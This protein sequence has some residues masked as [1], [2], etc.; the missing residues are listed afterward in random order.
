MCTVIHRSRGKKRGQG[1][2]LAGPGWE[3]KCKHADPTRLLSAPLRE[4]L[5]TAR[6]APFSEKDYSNCLRKSYMQSTDFWVKPQQLNRL[7]R[8][9]RETAN[10]ARPPG[11]SYGYR[12][13]KNTAR[14]MGKHCQCALKNTDVSSWK[15]QLGTEMWTH[16][17]ALLKDENI[18]IINPNLKEYL[19][20]IFL[21]L[22]AS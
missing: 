15:R 14:V 18:C 5:F 17:L 9:E 12:C 13:Y 19:H 20:Q 16:Q 1:E 21:F 22:W 6:L 7:Q 10:N 4:E 2:K 8:N 3:P 11:A